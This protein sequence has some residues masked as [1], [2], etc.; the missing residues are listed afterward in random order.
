MSNNYYVSENR[1][2]ALIGLTLIYLVALTAYDL[3]HAWQ[4]DVSIIS[5]LIW[6]ILLFYIYYTYYNSLASWVVRPVS[7]YHGSSEGKQALLSII[8]MILALLTLLIF[9]TWI[10]S[11]EGGIWLVMGIVPSFIVANWVLLSLL[12]GVTDRLPNGWE[13]YWNRPLTSPE[14]LDNED[15]A[16]LLLTSLAVFAGSVMAAY[17]S[18]HNL[19]TSEVGWV[20][21]GTFLMATCVFGAFFDQFRRSKIWGIIWIAVWIWFNNFSAGLQVAYD[22]GSY[23]NW[24]LSHTTAFFTSFH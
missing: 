3:W 12:L 15:K 13:T 8:V 10:S 5:V 23:F 16:A 4:T 6:D 2:I 20:I 1:R 9:V 19:G 14:R 18:Y 22:L 21:L 17:R 24:L 7:R 11:T